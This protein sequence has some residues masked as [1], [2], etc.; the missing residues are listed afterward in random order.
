LTAFAERDDLNGWRA[1]HG[2]GVVSPHIDYLRGGRVYSQVWRRAEAAVLEADLVLVFGTDHSGR[3]GQITLTAQP[4]ATPYGVLPGDT[5]LVGKLADALGPDAFADE[6]H[7]R[8]EHSVELSAVWLHHLRPN[9]PPPMVPVLCGSFEHFVADGRQPDGDTRLNAFVDTL[10][11]ATAGR[12]VLAVASADLAHVGPTFGDGFDMD[13]ARREEL[14]ASDAAL[15]EAMCAGDFRRFFSEVAQVGDR[16][17]ICGFSSIYL[18][19]RYLGQTEGQAVAYAH[20]PAD[21]EDASLVSIC[22]VLLA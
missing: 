12:R 18:L 21:A 20:C 11:E 6:L 16:N 4:Y 17:R 14:A 2:R 1:W 15:I 13:G 9:D 7:H 22:G 3:S 5:A 8:N 19:L 10:R